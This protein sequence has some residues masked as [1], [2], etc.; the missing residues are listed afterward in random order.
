MKFNKINYSR[1]RNRRRRE[2]GAECHDRPFET[3]YG[4]PGGYNVVPGP[5][6]AEERAG[7]DG[8]RVSESDSHKYPLID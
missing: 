7:R 8:G 1:P 5:G 2:Y 4:A 3:E 6:Q